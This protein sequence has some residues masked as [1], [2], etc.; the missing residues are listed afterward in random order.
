MEKLKSKIKTKEFKNITYGVC[1]IALFAWVVFRF[2]AIGS[3]KAM[4]VFNPTRYSADVGMPVYAIEMQKKT[5]V[6]QEPIEVKNNKA[7]VSSARVNKFKPGQIVGSGK[8]VS[9]SQDIDL[10][11]GMHVIRTNGVAD[12]L[13]YAQFQTNGYFVPLYAINDNKVMVSDD[14]IASAQTVS[15]IRQDAENALV[16]GLKDGDVVILSK[17]DAG[18]KIQIK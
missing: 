1:G 18:T 5:D 12:G 6:L 15:V 10:N 17:V 7:L 2:A 11:T 3:E 14:G 9:V 13:Q 8:I 4:S 16:E